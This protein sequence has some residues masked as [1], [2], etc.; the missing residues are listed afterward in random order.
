VTAELEVCGDRY[1]FCEC[2]LPRGHD[3][4]HGCDTACGGRW[5]VAAGGLRV[6]VVLPVG[7]A[8]AVKELRLR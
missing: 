8:E 7:L 4:L 5:A 3:G 2:V 1:W 6:P